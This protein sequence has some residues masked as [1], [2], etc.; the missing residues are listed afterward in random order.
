MAAVP[1]GVILVW[2]GTNASIPSGWSRETSLDEK[3]PKATANGVDPDVTGGSNTHT[4]TANAHGHTMNSHSHNVVLAHYQGSPSYSNRN[5]TVA[6]NHGHSSVA[7]AGVSGGSLA[8]EAKTWSSP[9]GTESEPPYHKVIFI[10]PTGGA[11]AINDDICMF[12]NSASAPQSFNFCDGDNG[13]TD[14]KDRYL[15]GADSAGDSGGTGG[16][17]SHQ[18]TITHGHTS[19]SHTHSAISGYRDNSGNRG[20]ASVGA[21]AHNTH[22]HTINLSGQSPG[23]NNYTNTTAGSAD[24]VE[25]AYKKLAVVQNTSGGTVGVKVGMIGMWLGTLASIPYGWQVCDGTNGTP[26]LREKF[27]KVINTTGQIGDT[28]GSNTHTH[29]AVSHTHTA[30]GTHS[31]GGSTSGANV[32][33]NYDSGGD[34]GS[35][36]SHTHG[37]DSCS[38]TTATYANSDIDSGDATSNEPAYRTVAYIQLI[39]VVEGA[40]AMAA[41]L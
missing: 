1:S 41:V 11:A 27:I 30:T 17:T 19:N 29:T 16:A 3:Y 36:L 31:H 12:W 10:S 5:D 18:H 38:S 39:K 21:G 20:N 24:T 6:D 35:P 4:H 26:D 15:K 2:T 32:Q 9:L 13:T 28:G 25:V 14:L 40:G 7:V 34:G 37:I 22:R 23:V 8:S 33:Q